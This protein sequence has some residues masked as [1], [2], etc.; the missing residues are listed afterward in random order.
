MK[1]ILI[2]IFILTVFNANENKLRYVDEIE[3]NET[4]T[5]IVEPKHKTVTEYEDRINKDEEIKIFA[6][7]IILEFEEEIFS[8]MSSFFSDSFR[9][10]FYSKEGMFLQGKDKLKNEYKI[11]FDNFF[12]RLVR[13]LLNHQN[14]IERVYISGHTSSVY[15]TAKNKEEKKL[16]NLKLSQRRAD[17][18]LSYLFDVNDKVIKENQ[19]W[20]KNTFKSVG[21]S[22]YAP[23]L[24]EDGKENVN[25][26]RRIELEIILK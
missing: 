3:I 21:M 24:Y 13:L 5:P 6:K 7:D 16:L 15:R 25:E 12:P 1:L 9:F 19:M 11:Y 17:A 26:S 22:S 8:G 18:V 2:G 20:M 23:I 10:V 4:V 14:L